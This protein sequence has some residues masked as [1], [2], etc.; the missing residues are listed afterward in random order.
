MSVNEVLDCMLE[1]ETLVST[2]PGT[3]HVKIA[4]SFRIIH[5][6][7]RSDF[8]GYW[9]NKSG[10]YQAWESVPSLPLE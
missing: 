9:C 2:V 4:S 3:A 5:L 1:A 7:S 10:C 8:K 6:G